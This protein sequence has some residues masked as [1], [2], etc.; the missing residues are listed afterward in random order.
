M[1]RIHENGIFEGSGGASAI[2]YYKLTELSKDGYKDKLLAEKYNDYYE[3]EGKEVTEEKYYEYVDAIESVELAERTEYTDSMLE[4]RLLG[5]L[6]AQEAAL[7]RRIP[8]EKM[9][10]NEPDYQIHK[11][12]M[13]LYA[14]VLSGEEEEIYVKV[15]E[16]LWEDEITRIYFSLIDMDRDGVCELVF[17]CYYCVIQIL[18]YQDG[19][20]YCYEFRPEDTVITTDG[21][22]NSNEGY[23]RIVSFEEDS[24]RIEPVEDYDR[25][26]HE[27]VRYYF[28]SEDTIKQWLE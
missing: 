17:S 23:A 19:E 1:K 24:C 14:K 10:E 8:A 15:D 5:N 16:W 2:S 7:V 21:V 3:V 27:W 4:Q 9:V 18:H 11:K 6:Q 26:K 22:F 20:V 25:D 28:Y 13:Q 12:A